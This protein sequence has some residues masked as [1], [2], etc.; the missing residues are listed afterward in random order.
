MD[1]DTLESKKDELHNGREWIIVNNKQVNKEY[2]KN[3]W[4]GN[5]WLSKQ[6]LQL[7]SHQA[8]FTVMMFDSNLKTAWFN[9]YKVILK[10]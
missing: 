2:V 5:N 10:I 7:G 9:L 1:L 4:F 8:S 6:Y 3:Q